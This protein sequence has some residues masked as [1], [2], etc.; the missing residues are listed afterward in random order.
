MKVSFIILATLVLLVVIHKTEG[1]RENHSGSK[2]Q[3]QGQNNAAAFWKR[4]SLHKSE[5]HKRLKEATE[6][7]I[8]DVAQS[9]RQFVPG[10]PCLNCPFPHIHRIIVHHHPGRFKCFRQVTNEG[11]Y[12]SRSE[13]RS[14]D[15]FE[16]S[17]GRLESRRTKKSDCFMIYWKRN[18]CPYFQA[19]IKLLSYKERLSR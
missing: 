13:N 14:S 19:A 6:H 17:Y 15:D 2:S 10:L 4:S 1:I 5:Q 16:R 8:N 11:S 7:K 18:A 3:R 12:S 9:K